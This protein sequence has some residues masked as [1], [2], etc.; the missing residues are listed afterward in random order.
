MGQNQTQLI[1]GIILSA[2]VVLVA[3]LGSLLY[4]ETA[5]VKLSVPPQ[6]LGATATL[7]GSQTGGDLKTQHIE[8]TATKSLDG[9][10]MTVFIEPKYATGQVVFKYS[11]KSGN[12]Q[13]RAITIAAGA[14]VNSATL[15]GYAT[16]ADAVVKP[17]TWTATVA[18]RA[19]SPG[20]AWNTAKN[21]ITTLNNNTL[22]DM[23]VSNPAAITGGTDGRSAPVIQQSD[24]DAVVNLLTPMV[25]DALEGALKAE[26]PDMSFIDN[27]PPLMTVT[28]DHKVGDFTRTFTITMTGRVGATAFSNADAVRLIRSAL[29]AKIPPDQELTKDQV[30]IT[31]QILQTS[32][33]GDITVNGTALG[34]ITPKLSTDT[35]RARIRGLSPTEARKSLE[36]AVPGSTVEIH[37]SPGLLPWLPLIGEH[38]NLSVVVLPAP[39]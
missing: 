10:A 25:S 33:N 31:W 36:R 32:P 24:W 22:P 3:A 19:T 23:H 37:V 28:S 30:Q 20:T 39:A 6:K 21:T 26:A 5:T 12:C 18:V 2:V 15:L 34:F 1:R 9:N 35:L 7:S 27:G 38:I 13:T 17:P 8:A 4:A 29:D 11:C 16:Q 14:L